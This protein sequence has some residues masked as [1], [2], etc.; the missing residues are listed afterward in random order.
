[1]Q[2][3][4]KVVEDRY[5]ATDLNRMDTGDLLLLDIARSLRAAN[6]HAE[7]G[8]AWSKELAKALE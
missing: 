3:A 7:E 1:M 8:L 5:A 2:D 4:L 6:K